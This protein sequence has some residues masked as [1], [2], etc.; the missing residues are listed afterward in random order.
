[1]DAIEIIKN[2]FKRIL[3]EKHYLIIVLTV[4]MAT[5]MLAVYFTAKFQIKANLA[6]VS[7][8]SKLNINSAYVQ[9]H[10]M[11]TVPEKSE[12]IM[13]K[14]DA[15]I[16]DKGNGSYKIDTFKGQ[17]FKT[18]LE[19]GI[20]KPSYFSGK[21]DDN[22]KAGT[23]ILGYLTMFILIEG[24]IFM[25]F[26]S[27]DKMTKAFKRIMTSP[28]SLK[29]YVL[30]HCI[31]NFIMMYIPT[32]IILIIEK[33]LLKVD[34]GFNYIQYS[35]LLLIITL[36]STAFAFFMSAV[37]ENSDDSMMMSNFIIILTSILSG[38]FYS[39]S[40]K[41]NIVDRLTALMPQKNFISLVEK[42]ENNNAISGYSAEL[43]YIVLII[44]IF[45]VLG[46]IICRTRFR[47][48]KY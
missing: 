40:S 13:G 42:I 11:K 36:L 19:R 22:R 14:Y 37:I 35:Y 46:T 17:E 41:N 33:E 31:F 32:F 10:L 18:M 29:S 23:N 26:F 48:G 47:Q 45:F 2:D 27:E 12:L 5:I 16:I 44:V 21:S 6:V 30:G 15:V 9:T 4:T 39:F 8:S 3:N 28:V 43:S 1:M 24:T 7:D 34:I 25:K 20:K 38:S